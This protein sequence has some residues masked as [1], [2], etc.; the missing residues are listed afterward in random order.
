MA[1]T[2]RS[3]L[4]GF[5]SNASPA[6]TT[7]PPH[8]ADGLADDGSPKP[9]GPKPR[10]PLLVGATR[11]DGMFENHDPSIRAGAGGLI[12]FLRAGRR[13]RTRPKIHLAAYHGDGNF[14]RRSQ[15]RHRNLECLGVVNERPTAAEAELENARAAASA[16]AGLKEFGVDP[17]DIK[18]SNSGSFAPVMVEERDPK[19]NGVLKRT[20]TGYRAENGL[21]VT[22]ICDVDKAGAIASRVVASGANF[23]RG[24]Y[25]SVS[26][27]EARE[28]GL[29]AA[30]VKE[31]MRKAALY[32]ARRRDEVRA[33]AGDRTKS[34]V[35][36]SE[37]AHA[38]ILR[39]T[40]HRGGSGRAGKCADR[41]H[42]FSDMGAC[43]GMTREAISFKRGWR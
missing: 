21:T 1:F 42:G 6:A 31:A 22:S 43:A 34:G 3:F 27:K 30:A 10:C 12:A 9:R 17:K 32:F 19:T 4:A 24:L 37:F 41:G 29:R 16:I 25:F 26:D 28:D 23:Y 14:V 8:V 7:A 18:T 33:A 35:R 36:S 11:K 20:L 13:A 38:K 5:I 15:A 2:R 39:R 40:A